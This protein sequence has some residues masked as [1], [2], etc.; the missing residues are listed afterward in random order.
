[1]MVKSKKFMGVHVYE[2]GVRTGD[3]CYYIKYVGKNGKAKLEKVGWK[4]EGYT[5]EQASK[6]RAFKIHQ[7]RHGEDLPDKNRK[8]WKVDEVF[9]K[10]KEHRLNEGV[11][12]PRLFNAY[13][14]WVQPEFG[15]KYLDEITPEMVTKFMGKLR[16]HLEDSTRY[17]QRF[18]L[19]ATF[20]FA[21]KSTEIGFRG[22][23]PVNKTKTIKVKNERQRI[24]TEDE[25]KLLLEKALT[26][27][28]DMYMFCLIGVSTGMRK[29]EIEN[30]HGRNIN[31]EGRLI[32]FTGKGQGKGKPRHVEICG[33]L[34]KILSEM[35]IKPNEKL[36]KRPIYTQQWKQLMV[37]TGFNDG[38][39]RGVRT[40][41][42]S[43]HTLRH[44]FGSTLAAQGTPINLVQDLMGHSQIS[45]TMRYLKHA[46]RAGSAEVNRMMDKFSV[47]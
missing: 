9:E 6:I 29:A 12:F 3:E 40:W 16:T 47:E 35:D 8:A 19:K 27:G 30:I 31:L 43:P 45:T 22:E 42:C 10:Y 2:S 23:N 14:K 25:V 24:L 32:S 17:T 36:F 39:E 5:Q 33:T 18:L 28:M 7:L 37:L 15:S 46:P 11:K 20:D 34:H 41:S 4:S 13:Y 44:T 38:V 21:I 26:M 1:M